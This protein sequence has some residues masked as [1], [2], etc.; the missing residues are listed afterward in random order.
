MKAMITNVN[1]SASPFNLEERGERVTND[2][3]EIA[4]LKTKYSSAP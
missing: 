4:R 3:A 2:N 1:F